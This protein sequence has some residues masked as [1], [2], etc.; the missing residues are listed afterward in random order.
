MEVR[1]RVLWE[2]G[3]QTEHCI[4]NLPDEAL[5]V[6]EERLEQ[7][8]ADYVDEE[9]RPLGDDALPAAWVSVS[10]LQRSHWEATR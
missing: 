7:G 1:L 5:E 10:V 3:Q 4:G 9:E 8:L 6:T 2:D